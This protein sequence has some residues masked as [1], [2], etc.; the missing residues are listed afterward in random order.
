M[1]ELQTDHYALK[2]L[3]TSKDL[4]GKLARWSLKLQMYNMVV[5]HRKGKLHRNVDALTRAEMAPVQLLNAVVEDSLEQ[6][7]EGDSED[8]DSDSDSL[9]SDDSMTEEQRLWFLHERDQ[10][11][12]AKLA[13]IAA[14]PREEGD[15]RGR[16]SEN[17]WFARSWTLSEEESM[18][19]P[20]YTANHDWE[21]EEELPQENSCFPAEVQHLL[22]QCEAESE[23]ELSQYSD[24]EMEI[25]EGGEDKPISDP[26]GREPV[27]PTLES[28][29]AWLESLQSEENHA[30]VIART[31]KKDGPESSN[32]EAQ[33]DLRFAE[34]SEGVYFPEKK[35]GAIAMQPGQ[36]LE[37]TRFHCAVC[38]R[39]DS[40]F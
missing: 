36:T 21:E 30:S 3:M 20:M 27:E 33:P 32:P 39:T 8:E 38:G 37:V 19:E 28:M 26:V 14:L 4:H 16:T 9:C 22:D 24:V 35:A 23:L 5:I 13:R 31:W 1:F 40:V 12:N 25:E 17:V 6:N 29:Q 34:V 18:E 2:W 10:F 11:V 15:S 7:E